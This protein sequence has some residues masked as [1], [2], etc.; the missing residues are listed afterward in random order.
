MLHRAGNRDGADPKHKAI[1]FL[2]S[3][4]AAPP[5]DPRL[6]TFP[7]HPQ[8]PRTGGGPTVFGGDTVIML[9]R[10]LGGYFCDQAHLR[11]GVFLSSGVER[12]GEPGQQHVGDQGVIDG[13]VGEPG[14]VG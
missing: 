1:S 8:Q 14:A 4:S 2:V 13:E 3:S 12:A 5:A 7:Q 11:V 10:S 9:M 6:T